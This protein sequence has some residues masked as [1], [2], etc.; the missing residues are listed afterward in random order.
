MDDPIIAVFT[1]ISEYNGLSLNQMQI[2]IGILAVSLLGIAH[3]KASYGGARFAVIGWPL[4]GIFFYLDVPHFVEIADPVLIIMCAA[5]LPITIILAIIEWKF[6]LNDV[7][8]EA[9]I[10]ARGMMALGV[11]PY[12]LIANIPYLNVA[13]VWLTAWSANVFLGFSGIDGYTLGTVIVDTG[14]SDVL[15]SEWSGNRWLLTDDL[16]DAGFYIPLIRESDGVTEVGFVMACSAMQSMA[17]FI[18]A[19]SAIRTA[20]VTRRIRA[21]FVTIPTIFVLNTFRNAGIVWLHASYPHW[22]L[23]G[24]TMFDFAHS[25]A[26]KFVSLGAMFL[27]ALVLFDLLPQ[28]HAHIMRLIAPIT[29]ITSINKNFSNKPKNRDTHK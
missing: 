21:A 22:E 23:L 2:F 16:G 24:V 10:W 8:D 13:A 1:W 4:V 5:G 26:A 29:K 7:E 14:V 25:Y 9:I 19:L 17:V 18:G 3:F 11:G 20:P 28:M 15:W 6:H 27:M 12:L